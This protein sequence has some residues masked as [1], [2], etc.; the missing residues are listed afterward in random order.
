MN[1]IIDL[2]KKRG[3]IIETENNQYI[4]SDN[5]AKKDAKLLED[6]LSEYQIGFLSKSSEIILTSSDAT[7]LQKLFS[8]IKIWNSRSWLLQSTTALA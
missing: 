8:P 7:R 2:L 1:Q 6:I 4:L 3:F 5:S